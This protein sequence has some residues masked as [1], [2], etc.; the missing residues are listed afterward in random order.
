MYVWCAFHAA[1]LLQDLLRLT[2]YLLRPPSTDA[3]PTPTRG[4]PPLAVV[5][6]YTSVA[7]HLAS[8]L[9]A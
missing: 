5:E 9:E 3:Q 6:S 2:D 4:P 7:G 8:T 1:F